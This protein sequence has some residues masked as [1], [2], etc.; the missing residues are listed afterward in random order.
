MITGSL[1][2]TYVRGRFMLGAKRISVEIDGIAQGSIET[3]VPRTFPLD[4]GEHLVVFRYSYM[5]TRVEL[6]L[7]GDDS[8]TVFWDRTMGGMRI[9]EE[10]GGDVFL[11]RSGWKYLAAIA[12]LVVIASA[13]M[14]MWM[15]GIIPI[16][17]AL[18]GHAV[19]MAVFMLL[20]I[21]ILRQS[22][23][24]FVWGKSR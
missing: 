20:L 21:S 22:S 13:I 15:E 24:T 23:R 19:L 16:R 12:V 14:A 7:S 3:G 10:F 9:A 1:T 8:F 18:A 11:D 17:Y 2:V 5:R 6:T 4:D